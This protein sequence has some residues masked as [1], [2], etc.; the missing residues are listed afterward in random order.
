MFK[1]CGRRI[2]R[3][4]AVLGFSWLAAG[5][6]HHV[7]AAVPTGTA[8]VGMRSYAAVHRQV[9]DS[10]VEI[11]AMAVKTIVKKITT[12]TSMHLLGHKKPVW[13]QV[14]KTI[15]TK[16]TTNSVGSGVILSASGYIVTNAHVV[17]DAKSVQVILADRRQCA[18]TIVGTDPVADLAVLK[19]VAPALKPARLG[20][21]G[22]LQVGQ[23]VV[24]FG[25]P[26]RLMQSMTHGIISALHRRNDRVTSSDDPEVKLISHEDFIQTDAPTDPGSSGGA[27]VDMDGRVI[28]INESI[29]SNGGGGFSGVGFVIPSDEVQSVM[30]Q[31]IAHHY[32]RHG[33]LGIRMNETTVNSPAGGHKL[34]T[35]L[36]VVQTL[37]TGAAWKAGLRNGDIILSLDGREIHRVAQLRNYAEF[38]PPGTHMALDVLRGKAVKKF[39]VITGGR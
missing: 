9:R 20:R 3:L 33:H 18:A 26:Y 32:V 15:T 13:H 31:I 22:Q 17:Y 6:V 37:K 38:Q 34:I 10:V 27:L 36:R 11:R 21:S 28:G 25:S 14:S 29:D 23:R 1:Q 16:V 39:E 2:Y 24:D 35:G 12:R 5:L 8:A 30:T 7:G 19:I 4:S